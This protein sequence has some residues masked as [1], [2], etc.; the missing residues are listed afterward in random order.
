MSRVGKAKASQT[1]PASETWWGQGRR[2]WRTG[3][4]GLGSWE[5]MQGVVLL[6]QFFPMAGHIAWWPQ[7]DPRDFTTTLGLIPSWDSQLSLRHD[8][9]WVVGEGCGLQVAILPHLPGSPILIS[10]LLCDLC[11]C[12]NHHP[13]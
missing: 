9:Y 12:G 11:L 1:N 10:P 3:S 4:G 6:T 8:Q 13:S 7:P 5:D 2:G